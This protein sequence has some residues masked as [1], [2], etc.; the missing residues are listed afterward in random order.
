MNAKK[1]GI[2]GEKQALSYLKNKGYKLIDRNYHTHFGEIDLIMQNK[3]NLVFVEVK[4]RKGDK[5]G[6][7]EEAI[8]PR[9]IRLIIKSTQYYQLTHPKLSESIRI[10][11]VAINIDQVSSKVNIRHIKNISM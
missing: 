6:L 8:T 4:T 3:D 9:K 10:D 1:L 7:A 5:Y 11:L 2:W